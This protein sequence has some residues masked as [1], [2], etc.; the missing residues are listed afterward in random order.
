MS[1]YRSRLE[2]GRH[3]RSDPRRGQQLRDELRRLADALTP[4]WQAT[5]EHDDF[6]SALLRIGARL[7][8][9]STMRLDDTAKRDA[10][11]FFDFLGLS[12]DPPRAA[13]GV[14]I[15]A[16]EPKQV[17]PVFAPVRTQV[18]VTADDDQQ[19][20]FETR[21]GLRVI[22]G[23]IAELVAVDTTTDHIE[24]SPAQVTSYLA[25]SA[26]PEN[27]R[28]VTFSGAGSTTIQLSPA[29]GLKEGDILRIGD[30]A[31]RVATEIEESGLVTLLDALERPATAGTTVAQRISAFETFTLRNIQQHRF[32]VGHA[33]LLNLE[34]RA[35][36]SLEASPASLA[37]QIRGLDI[38][39][40]MYGTKRG[41]DQPGWQPLEVLG[42]GGSA[43]RLAKTW[44]GTTDEF[45]VN[46]Q[47][48][49]WIRAEL[50]ERIID[51]LGPTSR[52]SRILLTV[53]SVTEDAEGE[54]GVSGEGAD[55]H[56]AEGSPTVAH[57]A[58]NGNPLA[59]T[60]RF[61]PFGPEPIRFDTF[62]LAAPE[63]LSKKGAQVRLDV[64]LA[65]SSMES[66]SVT[67]AHSV[68][69]WS[70]YGI[71]LN[72]DLQMLFHRNDRFRWLAG[73]V[74]TK[75]GQ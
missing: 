40:S 67:T 32:Y 12:P 25:P 7:A 75:E 53:A 10:L 21:L 2:A 36:I 3:P 15:L 56:Q 72:G 26:L 45:E 74:E 24:R 4:R 71:G 54:G 33:E 51:G 64:T 55:R 14:L 68:E 62:A 61:Y 29:A 42:A 70:G 5:G 28:F 43:I 58:H 19:A 18:A 60:G 66:F 47:K 59:T 57:A 23:G 8:E 44:V 9:Q 52:A 11:A 73:S 6:G 35:T 37:A 1:T 46:G 63:A 34:Q 49:R 39:Y 17:M 48:S 50:R 16:L 41:E 38:A 65:D 27:Y 20:L 13:S 31:H 30:S 69:P 22:P